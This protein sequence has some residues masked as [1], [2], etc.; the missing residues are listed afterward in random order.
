[1]PYQAVLIELKNI[2]LYPS[3][4]SIQLPANTFKSI[5]YCGATVEYQCGRISE[6][7]YFV[8]LASDFGHSREEIETAI[9][10]IRKSSRVNEAVLESLVA[11]KAQFEGRVKIYAVTNLSQQDYALVRGLGIDWSLFEQIF[12]SSEM[13]MR[14]PELRVYQRVLDAIGLQARQVIMVDDDTDNVLAA[15]S[16]GL[17]GVL[18]SEDSFSHSILDLLRDEPSGRDTKYLSKQFLQQNAQNFPSF[19]HT[20]VPV[21]E[22]FAQLLILDLTGDPNLVDIETHLTTWNYFIG[23]PVLT[24][25]QFPDD[26]DTT[27]LGTTIFNRPP[28]V[29]DLVMDKMLEYRTPDGLMQTFFTDFKNRVDPVVCCNVLSLFYQY[30]RGY[31]LSETLNWVQ[32]VLQRRAYIHGTSFYPVPEAFFFFLSRLLLRLKSVRARVYSRMRYLLIERLEERIGVPVDAA[33]LAMR[34]IVCRQVGIR[35]VRGLKELLSMQEADGGW[36]MGTLYHY[37][38]KKLRLGNRGASTALALDAI[39]RCQPWLSHCG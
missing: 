10:A 28:H 37:A 15:L 38:S 13:G 2:L 24:Q 20:G 30:R 34:L 23:T 9:L 3:T 39:R 14:K 19:T 18:S 36:E 1:M 7:Q 6:E 27:S 11:M 33:S 8:R 31:Q 12:V 25:A 29:A 21:K 35:D 26:M 22:N 17:Q 4:E 16:L 5:L 32:Q